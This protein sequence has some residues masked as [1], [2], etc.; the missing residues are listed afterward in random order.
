MNEKSNIMKKQNYLLLIA[1]I[2]A[3]LLTGCFG[4]SHLFAKE[5]D[6]YTET[7]EEYDARVQWFRNAKL[8][9][10][11]HWNPS[12]LI[13]QEIGWSRDKYGPEKYDQLYKQFIG[14]D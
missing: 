4:T 5:F 9:V 14:D 8:G 6:P 3:V 10:F 1:V 12:S 11:I 7:K 13:G 2:A